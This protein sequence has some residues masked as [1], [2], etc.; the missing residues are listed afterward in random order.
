MTAFIVVF[1]IIVFGGFLYLV[2]F[3]PRRLYAPSDFR[4]DPSYLIFSGFAH[5]SA[6]GREPPFGEANLPSE[7]SAS[8][9]L[10]P[11]ELAFKPDLLR[12]LRDAVYFNQRFIFLGHL[13]RPS[14]SSGYKYEVAIFLTGWASMGGLGSVEK[15]R[16]YLG[17]AWRSQIFDATRDND[18]RL[19]IV[20]QSHDAFLALC[21]VVFEDG[22]VVLLNHFCNV[23]TAIAA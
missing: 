1:P 18:G 5:V 22:A 7:F 4:D 11:S 9:T 17:P 15:A 13:V 21:E 14:R 2:V 10:A 12:K 20:T 19:G 8:D 6:Q 3:Q 16:F 23:E